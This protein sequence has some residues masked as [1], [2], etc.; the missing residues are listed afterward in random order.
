MS[1]H[2]PEN[3]SAVWRAHLPADLG[4]QLFDLSL[5]TGLGVQ[6]DSRVESARRV[7]EKLLV[8]SVMVR[9]DF[10]ASILRLVLFVMARSV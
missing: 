2:C 3:L 6:T 8:P 4:V 1:A 10:V 9:M 5:A 7:F